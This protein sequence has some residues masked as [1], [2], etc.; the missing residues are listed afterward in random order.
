MGMVF[1]KYCGEKID[2]ECVICIKCGKQV[3]EVQSKDSGIVINN[4]AN[5]S[6]SASSQDK[7]GRKCNKWVSLFL[8]LFTLFG[9]KIYEGKIMMA[10]VYI[11]T[12]GFLGVGLII[13]IIKI[14][15]KPN[16]YYV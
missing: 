12:A 1:C 14:L 3:K 7:P 11:F 4:S 10:I 8:C 6:A 13:D 16:P 9:H 2:E 5:A 15:G